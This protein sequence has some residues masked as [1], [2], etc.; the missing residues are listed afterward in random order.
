MSPTGP[1]SNTVTDRADQIAIDRSLIDPDRLQ[2]LHTQ[3]QSTSDRFL[4]FQCE[5][6]SSDFAFETAP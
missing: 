3:R 5:P 1:T 2:T 4:K 6:L